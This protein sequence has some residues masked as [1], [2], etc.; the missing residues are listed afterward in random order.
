MSDVTIDGLSEDE[1]FVHVLRPGVMLTDEQW[2]GAIATACSAYGLDQ[3]KVL[4]NPYGYAPMPKPPEGNADGSGRVWPEVSIDV[5]IHPVFW[6]DAETR[7]RRPDEPDDLYAV[8]LHLELLSRKMLNPE[9]QEVHSPFAAQGI[10]DTNPEFEADLGRYIGGQSVAWLNEFVV[11]APDDHDTAEL[12]HAADKLVKVHRRNY[13]TLKRHL[14]ER[15]A[16]ALKFAADQIT[17]ADFRSSANELIEGGKQLLANPDADQGR[18]RV[19]QAVA[20]LEKRLLDLDEWRSTVALAVEREQGREASAINAA[21]QLEI[22]A[23]KRARSIEMSL[24]GVLATPSEHTMS[25]LWI[26]LS[27]LHNDL[28][29]R[30]RDLVAQL[31]QLPRSGG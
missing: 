11:P 19:R 31:N 12:H 25:D 27:H 22:Q 24:N 2:S 14:T 16:E 26:T 13:T 4:S 7:R 30:G 20:D 9:S 21:T 23:D 15:A 8:R 5:A 3:T 10:D 18:A 29:A 6:L 1:V 28:A 17:Q